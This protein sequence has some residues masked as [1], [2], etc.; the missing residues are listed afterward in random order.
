MGPK[1]EYVP[2]F[3]KQLYECWQNGALEDC[4]PQDKLPLSNV[5]IVRSYVGVGKFAC[6]DS[7]NFGL[8][9][10]LLRSNVYELNI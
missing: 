5:D 2:T 6:A 9:A 3:I 7:I 4:I 10:L 1:N 8:L